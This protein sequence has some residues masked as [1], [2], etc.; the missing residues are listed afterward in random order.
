MIDARLQIKELLEGIEL[1]K[2]FK[3][4]MNFP[5]S[6]SDGVMVTYFELLNKSTNI[7]VVDEIA[8]QID[9]WA[10]DMETLVELSQKVDDALIGMGLLRQFTSP[11]YPPD[12][13]GRYFRK[14]MRYGRRADTRTNRL[15]D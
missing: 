10:Y 1:S 3:V 6:V 14:T 9:C 12:E 2:P 5:Q 15:I 7:P 13:Q 11:D 8:F 4:K